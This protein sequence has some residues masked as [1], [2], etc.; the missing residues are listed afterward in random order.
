MRGNLQ[1]ES[2]KLGTLSVALRVDCNDLEVVQSEGTI[3]LA[4]RVVNQSF[5]IA[6]SHY[7]DCI[8]LEAMSHGYAPAIQVAWNKAF[9]LASQREDSNI[10]WIRSYLVL[11][12][13]EKH[14]Y[15]QTQS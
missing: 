15:A 11:E 12:Q 3:L 10:T 8:N 1:A 4:A 6:R 13:S 9:C 2:D 14:I 7:G 5:M